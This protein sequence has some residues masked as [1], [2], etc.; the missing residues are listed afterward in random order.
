MKLA[1]LERLIDS[2]STFSVKP[3]SSE[4]WPNMPTLGFTNQTLHL[5][6]KSIGPILST[7]VAR[8]EDLEHRLHTLETA[9]ARDAL[10]AD[11]RKTFE[12]KNVT[13]P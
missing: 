10:N 6:L 9:P 7:L 3:R 13:A 4:V 1:D 12:S 11:L 2:R 8:L 5:P